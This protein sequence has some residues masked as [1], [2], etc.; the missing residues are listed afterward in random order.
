MSCLID[1]NAWIDEAEQEAIDA[2][3]PPAWWKEPEPE[4]EQ[5]AQAILDES[6]NYDEELPF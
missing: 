4:L 6:T 5:T 1:P 3:S 2:Q